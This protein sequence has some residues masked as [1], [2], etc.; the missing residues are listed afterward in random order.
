MSPI[1][2]RVICLDLEGVLVPEIWIAVA[3]KTKIAELRRT[4]RDEP[5]YDKLMKFRIG[6]LK[7][8]G[9][10]LAHIQKVIA[11]MGP[12]PG[13]AKFIHAARS[14]HQVI[15]LSDTFAQ[16]A[17]PLMKQ[18]G[19]PTIFCNS[20]QTDSRGFI[21]RHVMRQANGKEHAVRALHGLNFEV[22]A[23]GDSFNDLTMIQNAD[24][25]VFFR[26]P[27]AIAVRF[28]KIRV[29]QT[30]AQLGKALFR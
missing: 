22:A 24:V 5:D 13:A 30:Y 8:S 12:L 16:F 11:G 6:I 4:T 9:I 7:R 21:A 23:A 20:L 1:R 19:W 25:G 14:R 26:P 10:R 28:P 18:L 2:P 15:I 27:R 29:C 3:E 17:A